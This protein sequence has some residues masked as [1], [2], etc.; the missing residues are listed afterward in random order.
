[1]L[2]DNVRGK[3]TKDSVKDLA[4][5]IKEK[6]V[7]QAILVRPNGNNKFDLVAGF[8]RTI[9][10]G[11]AGLETIPAMI[12]DIEDSDRLEIQMIENLQREDLDPIAEAKALD[13]LLDEMELK[14]A[15]VAL[16]KT[17]LYIRQ[18]TSL[19]SLNSDIQN[20]IK[21]GKL[22]A[23]HGVVIARLK[24]EKLQKKLAHDIKIERMTVAQAE[25]QISYNYTNS[26]ESCNFDLTECKNCQ[27]NGSKISDLFDKNNRLKDKC[28]NQDCFNKKNNEYVKSVIEGI[29]KLGK[30]IIDPSKLYELRD[31]V[32]LDKYA[33]EEITQDAYQLNCV[34]CENLAYAIDDF[35]NQQLLCLNN[36]CFRRLKGKIK[37]IKNKELVGEK[38]EPSVTF[39][40]RQQANRID[41]T[42]RRFYLKRLSKALSSQQFHSLLV[43][44]LFQQE[45]GGTE[46]I[47]KYLQLKK[48]KPNYY[49]KDEEVILKT[50]NDF[51]DGK[52]KKLTW[53][54]VVDRLNNYSTKLIEVFANAQGFDIGKQFEIDK[55]YLERMTK[56][57]LVKLAKEI[58]LNLEDDFGKEKKSIMI[59]LIMKANIKRQIPN[60]LKK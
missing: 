36:K 29:K 46:S 13:S 2:H 10:A 48:S 44:M 12:Q 30:K 26:L 60:E 21:E 27:F 4:E 15:T 47:S 6:G 23:A 45:S 17:P 38:K 32:R 58:K 53:D 25:S 42:K 24:S 31:Y 18:R 20:L 49:L 35:G 39:E 22:S 50:L 54:I 34:P 7:L 8:R 37:R 3:V 14:D 28:L 43:H 52:L 40:D 57:S 11:V 56:N 51:T 41:E 9:A 59:S 1:M 33:I 5:S 16:G 19:L 55:L